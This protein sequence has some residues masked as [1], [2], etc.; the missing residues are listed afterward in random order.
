MVAVLS[1]DLSDGALFAFGEQWVELLA[2]D[3]YRAAFDLLLCRPKHPVKSW[4]TSPE[5]LR[6]WVAGYG[7]NEPEPDEPPH[8]V[9]SCRTAEARPWAHGVIRDGLRPCAEY[10]LRL[11]FTIPL[12]GEWSDLVASFD[13]IRVEGGM[14]PVLAALRIP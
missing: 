3:N 2:Q 12:D 13:F 4:C 9:T 11:D 6:A 14:S 5:D 7:T 10:C 8:V 1:E